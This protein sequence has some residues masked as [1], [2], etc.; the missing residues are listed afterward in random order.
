MIIDGK[1]VPEGKAPIEVLCSQCKIMY[2]ILW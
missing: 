1:Q 2:L